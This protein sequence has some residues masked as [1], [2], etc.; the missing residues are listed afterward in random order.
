MSYPFCLRGVPPLVWLGALAGGCQTLRPAPHGPDNTSTYCAPPQV[1]TTDTLLAAGAPPAPRPPLDTTARPLAARSWQLARAYGLEP[2]LRQLVQRDPA[3]R[4]PAL[5]D[6]LAFVRRRQVAGL[7]VARAT[8][9]ALRV[10]GELECAR[11]RADQS[12]VALQALTTQRTNR[13]TV[14]SLLMGA[15]SGTISATVQNKETNLVL[16]VITAGLSAGLGAGALL[17]GPQLPYPLPHNLLAPVWDQRPRPALYPPGLWAALNEVRVG[18]AGAALP[19]PLARLRQRWAQYDQL[20]SGPP[21]QQARQQ[22]LY[23]GAGG[24]YHV[25]ELQTRARMLTLLETEVRLVA[26]DLQKLGE[27]LAAIEP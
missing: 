14:A 3:G 13:F 20:T 4:A 24:N 16:T 27:E 10:A 9:E 23:F 21:A 12:A 18:R 6:Y 2:A 22:A 7:A 19:P 8:G 26:Q 11:Q 25:A 15:A 1:F 5:A 17:V